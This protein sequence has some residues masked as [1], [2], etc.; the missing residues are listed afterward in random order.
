MS[1]TFGI[2]FGEY[3]LSGERHQ[4]I[5]LRSHRYSAR[6][7]ESNRSL[8]R[9]IWVIHL[10]KGESLELFANGAELYEWYP[11]TGLDKADASR[12]KARPDASVTY[13]VVGKR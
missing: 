9:H 5:W 8:C 13:R 7:R 6:N 2:T 11:A 3:H 4:W 10:C 1:N 12:P